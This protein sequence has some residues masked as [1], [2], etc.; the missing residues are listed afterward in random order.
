MIISQILESSNELDTIYYRFRILL[1]L[2]TYRGG[3]FFLKF[4]NLLSSVHSVESFIDVFVPIDD[5][6]LLITDKFFS[7]D[8]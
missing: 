5:F 3:S 4:Y 6:L 2:I 8:L 7:Y 1:L